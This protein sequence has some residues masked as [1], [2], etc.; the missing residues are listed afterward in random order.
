M[1]VAHTI[2]SC[3]CFASPL[4]IYTIGWIVVKCIDLTD[5]IPDTNLTKEHIY[6]SVLAFILYIFLTLFISKNMIKERAIFRKQHLYANGN[7]L[8][9]FQINW[10]IICALLMLP[11]SIIIVALIYFANYFPGVNIV[12]MFLS[13]FIAELAIVSVTF[14]ISSFFSKPYLGVFV[15]FILL[16][17]IVGSNYINDYYALYKT[18]KSRNH[19]YSGINNLSYVMLDFEKAHKRGDTVNFSNLFNHDNIWIFITACINLGSVGLCILL[20]LFN[21][22]FTISKHVSSEFSDRK[23]RPYYESIVCNEHEINVPNVQ[24]SLNNG[25]AVVVAKNLFKEYHKNKI[26]AVNNA[27]FTIYNNEVV[28]ITGNGDSGKSTLMKMLYGRIRTSYG[29]IFI[30]NKK[31]DYWRWGIVSR[32]ISVAPKEDYV[33]FKGLTVSDNIKYYQSISNT[34]ENGFTLLN[35]LNFLGSYDDKIN[36]LKFLIALVIILLAGL[37]ISSFF[38]GSLNSGENIL[39]ENIATCEIKIIMLMN[40]SYLAKV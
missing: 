19:A 13:F 6:V 25:K 12:I 36:Y 17:V 40:G 10:F 39:P 3:V 23:Q 9:G 14:Y 7:H 30:N 28:A 24:Q 11:T 20:S 35:E 22:F 18:G 5:D 16:I 15:N 31:L 4:V 29:N 21:D 38:T 27:S 33:F 26:I 8:I 37:M 2:E 32:Q 34:R 1:F